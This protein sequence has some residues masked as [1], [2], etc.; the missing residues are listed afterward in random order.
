MKYYSFQEWNQ[1]YEREIESILA[2]Y[3]DFV[4]TSF[5]SDNKVHSLN[6][7]LFTEQM[8][9]LIYKTSVNKE[10]NNILYL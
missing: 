2:D 4:M 6:I 7:Q 1:I 3:T 8:R 5:T 10:K 9:K